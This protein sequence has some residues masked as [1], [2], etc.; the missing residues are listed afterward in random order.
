MSDEHG[1]LRSRSD[2]LRAYLS[3]NRNQMLV[4]L[5][6]L[7]AWLI[8][9]YTIFGILGLP[10]WFFYL[11]LFIGVIAYSRVTPPWSRPYRSPDLDP[12]SDEL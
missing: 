2:R 10:A 12:D 8:A 9:T 7:T 1:E 5:L 4:D 6:V 11:I 3:Y